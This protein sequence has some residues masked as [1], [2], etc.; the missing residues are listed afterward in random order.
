MKRSSVG[1]E[2]GADL[3]ERAELPGLGEVLDQLQGFPVEDLVPALDGEQGERLSHVAL[4]G[5]RRSDEEG[6]LAGVDELQGGE[7]EDVALGEAGVVGPVE[8]LRG[9]F[10]RGARTGRGVVPEDGSDGGR[11]R[12]G[13]ARRRPQG[14]PSRVGR[15][16]GR[17]LRG[18]RSCRTGAGPRARS[19]SG[20]DMAMGLL[21]GACDSACSQK[22][23]YRRRRMAGPDWSQGRSSAG[24]AARAPRH[25]EGLVGE[26]AHR[27]HYLTRPRSLAGVGACE[28]GEPVQRRWPGRPRRA[29]S[30]WQKL[31][32]WGPMCGLWRGDARSRGRD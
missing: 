6:V 31:A 7:L 26:A 30:P 22:A 29:K 23:W 13:R 10:G 19:S 21:L 27:Q 9:S 24:A 28:V 12:P 16:G 3:A 17:G 25:A 15:P 14:S 20:V 1:L 2:L 18:W 32:V 8:V 5:A 4:A 11:V